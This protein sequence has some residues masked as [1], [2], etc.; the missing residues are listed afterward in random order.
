MTPRGLRQVRARYENFGRGQHQLHALGALRQIYREASRWEDLVGTLRK[1]IPLQLEA[2]GVKE[3]RFELAEVF[4]SKVNQREEA[5]ES[6]KRVL[7]VEPAAAPRPDRPLELG[8]FL[9]GRW[10][11]GRVRP[12]TYPVH[13]AFYVRN[14]IVD[15]L[16]AASLG[17]VGPIYATLYVAPW[18]RALGARIGRFVELSTAIATAVDLLEI[19]DGGTVA[20]EAS[21]GT[22]HVEGGWMTVAPTRLGRRAFVGNSGVLP[23]GACMGEGS[24]VGVLSI[25][26]ARAEDAGR[27]GAS[28]MGSPPIF[29]PRRQESAAFGE[30]RTYR[31][32]RAL[33]LARGAFELLRVTLPPAGLILVSAFVV[34]AVLALQ[35]RLGLG[36]ALALLPLAYAAALAALLAAVAL[37]K[38]AVVGRYRAFARPL[39]SLFV[40]RLEL[41]NAL[42]EFLAAPLALHALRG[43]PLLP[44]YLRLL[45]VRIGRRVYANTTG[46]LEW[47]LVRIGDRVA[48]NEHCV[49][50]THLFE[51]RILKASR[52]QIGDDC[53]VGARSVVLYDS[54]ME[55][56]AQLDALSLLMKGETLPAGT[57]WAGSPAACAP[58]MPAPAE[59][60]RRRPA[61]ARPGRPGPGRREDC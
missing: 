12:G 10:W 16:L 37:A 28:W 39:W 53:T 56:G 1:L 2:S 17:I 47:D 24:L 44:W 46:F 25:A 19:A 18:Y 42:Y 30:A 3:I 43:T 4:L 11:R 21:L 27:P 54:T 20:D 23:T 60:P 13:G 5:I 29:L 59:P 49:L 50:Q 14:W 33:R 22:P 41:V 7:D 31:P 38:W 15:Q 55:A 32:P 45:G 34:T 8:I 9:D 35:A 51:D 57:A 40:W 6:A 52:L 48:L 61:P 26:P 36:A 58:A